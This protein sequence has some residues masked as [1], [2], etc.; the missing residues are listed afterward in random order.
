[1][2]V[3][4]SRG[5]AADDAVVLHDSNRLTVRLLPGDVLARVAPA[6]HQVARFEVEL[7][8]RLAGSGCP[9]AGTTDRSAKREFNFPE[10]TVALRAEPARAGICINGLIGNAF[11]KEKEIPGEREYL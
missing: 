9:V 11:P 5:L 10:R 7:A 2:S 8:Q 4:S 6:A 1:M 3:A